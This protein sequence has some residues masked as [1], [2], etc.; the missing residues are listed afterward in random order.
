[1]RS[2]NG[3]LGIPPAAAGTVMQ[4]SKIWDAVSDPM[5]GAIVTGPGPAGVPAGSGD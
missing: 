3:K 4:I 1:M 2:M 5:M